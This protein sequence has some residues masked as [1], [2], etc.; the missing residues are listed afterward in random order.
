VIEAIVYVAEE[1][2]TVAQL[3]NALGQPAERVAELLRPVDG[4]V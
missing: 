3:A 1:P 4:G 2:L